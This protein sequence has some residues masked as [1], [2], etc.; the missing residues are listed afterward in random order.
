MNT[1]GPS[2]D[3]DNMEKQNKFVEV[4]LWSFQF[5]LFFK[6]KVLCPWQCPYSELWIIN[7]QVVNAEKQLWALIHSKGLL[8]IDVQDLY[9]K[10]RCGY[11]NMIL[12]D[13]EAMELQDVEYCLWKLHYKH[14]DEFRR[15][16][17]HI[18][19]STETKKPGTLQ[20][21]ANVQNSIDDHLEGFKS[22][23]S[24][25]SEFYKNLIKKLKLSCG[26]P[27]EMLLD[28]MD[29]SSLLVEPTKFHKCKYTCHRFLVCLGDLARYR[30]LCQKSDNRYCKWS[31]AATYYFEAA[32]I[33]P[34]S[35]NP[36]NQVF[37]IL[38]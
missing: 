22:F 17:R 21:V 32:S 25:A 10:A 7:V 37:S 26:L 27:E 31:V 30:E 28:H 5:L 14:I 9:R 23:L 11:E 38:S 8:R 19:G 20:D 29:D 12:N 35:G 34:D 3:E 24:E 33:C 36:Q 6:L 2:V 15:K 18:S 4:I 1:Y 13:H 16:I